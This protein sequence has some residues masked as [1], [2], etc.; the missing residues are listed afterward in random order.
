MIRNNSRIKRAA[1]LRSAPARCA[2]LA[3]VI[4]LL[5]T[6]LPLSSGAA[7]PEKLT[8]AKYFTFSDPGYLDFVS[9]NS[10]TYFECLTEDDVTFARIH[11]VPSGGDPFIYMPVG[12]IEG[13]VSCDLYKYVAF[14]MRAKAGG[15]SNLYFGT[16]NEGGLD[17]SKN[18]PSANSIA[19]NDQWMTLVFDLSGH[20][21]WNGFLSTARFDPYGNVPDG[22]EYI[23]IQWI[24]FVKEDKDLEKLDISLEELNHQDEYTRRPVFATPDRTKPPENTFRPAGVTAGVAEQTVRKGFSPAVLII[25]SSVLLVAAASAAAGIIVLKKKK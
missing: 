23:D 11:F 1:R 13:G 4:M 14:R 6:W 20:A 7:D 18:Q 16:S 12:M 9:G 25:V 19:D 22:L 21:K 5:C 8:D 15:S 17:E 24:A 3:A 10:L 2:V